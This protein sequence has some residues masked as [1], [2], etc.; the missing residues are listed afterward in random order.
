[1]PFAQQVVERFLARQDLCF[2][3]SAV[4][5]AV[6]NANRY[7][8]TVLVQV[9]SGGLDPQ[10]LLELS[11]SIDIERALEHKFGIGLRQDG[12]SRGLH[13]GLGR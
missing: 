7:G 10:L 8:E 9:A 2:E 3:A 6:S 4:E 13:R 5:E 12:L 11:R 1:M